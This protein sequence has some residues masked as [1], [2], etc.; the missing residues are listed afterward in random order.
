MEIKRL[1]FFIVTLFFLRYSSFDKYAVL[2][3]DE[4]GERRRRAAVKYKESV[5][6]YDD[7][8]LCRMMMRMYTV[9]SA[10]PADPLFAE[11]NDLWQTYRPLENEM[12]RAFAAEGIR[13]TAV[14]DLGF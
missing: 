6:K 9:A 3:Y 1:R 8:F 14:S 10:D 11:K 12:I 7:L 2:Y 13:P 5:M 4:S